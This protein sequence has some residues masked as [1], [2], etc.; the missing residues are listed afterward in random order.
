MVR[1][2]QEMV[3][4]TG[5]SSEVIVNFILPYFVL[6]FQSFIPLLRM[7]FQEEFS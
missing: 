2:G 6:L 1:E 4:I 7:L 5:E 3:N